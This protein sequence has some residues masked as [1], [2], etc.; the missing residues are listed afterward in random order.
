MSWKKFLVGIGIGFTGALLLKESVSQSHIS[1]EK[2]L[3]IA[4]ASFK[5]NGPID[6]SWI[7]M[8][9]ELYTKF[10]LTYKVYKGGISRTEDGNL[11]QYEFV[12]DA[13]NG[14]IIDVSPL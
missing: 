14:T 3:K 7:H 2:A 6:G 5:Q 12:I 4:K 13:K 8:N 9:P 1:A 11:L 10:N